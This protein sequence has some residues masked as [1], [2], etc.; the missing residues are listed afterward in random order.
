MKRWI[1]IGV[2]VVAFAGFWSISTVYT[3][4]LEGDIE[5]WRE[6]C[7][8]LQAELSAPQALV[9]ITEMHFE[10]SDGSEGKIVGEVKNIKSVDANNVFVRVVEYRG[11]EGVRFGDFVSVDYLRAGENKPFKLKVT[12]PYCDDEWIPQI[13]LGFK[14]V[15]QY[16]REWKSQ[17][18]HR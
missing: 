9:E 6:R 17:I 15:G 1:A 3:A 18:M 13:E 4:N 10:W 8:K 16:G 12:K 7:N 11:R 5:F 14:T 2:L